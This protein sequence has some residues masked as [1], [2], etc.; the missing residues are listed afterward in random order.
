M[1]RSWRASLRPAV[2]WSNYWGPITVDHEHELAQLEGKGHR[3]L[4]T[5]ATHDPAAGL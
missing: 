1:P 4:R 2:R 3:P 5:V